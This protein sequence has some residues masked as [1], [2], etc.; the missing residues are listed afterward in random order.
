MAL[1][2][3]TSQRPTLQVLEVKTIAS[4]DRHR[5]L[6][7]DGVGYMQGMLSQQLNGLVEQRLLQSQSVIKLNEYICNVVQ[8]RKIV[9][10]LNCEVLQSAREGVIGQP[11]RIDD[12]GQL[13]SGAFAWQPP[14][15]PPQEPQPQLQAYQP[16]PASQQLTAHLPLPMYQP[17]PPHPPTL[18]PPAT[19]QPHPPPPAA[20]YYAPIAGT[21]APVRTY[22]NCPFHEKDVCKSLGAK[23][24][25]D[26][27]AWY[28]PAGTNIDLFARWP[29]R[30]DLCALNIP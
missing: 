7:S 5:L 21:I 4:A 24:D 25:W 15:P 29:K 2:N 28:V 23:F 16:P 27:K 12:Q 8:A 9:I 30:A 3:D 18:Q 14:P 6:L 20:P 17:P 10:V 19:Y 1:H 13:I 26:R 11:V 22:L